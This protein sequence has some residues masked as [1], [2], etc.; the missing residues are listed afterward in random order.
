ME[1]SGAIIQSCNLLSGRE[2]MLSIG[3]G[4]QLDKRSLF[5]QHCRTSIDEASG[6]FS[7][8]FASFSLV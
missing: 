4:V 5:L 7:A 1:F 3:D 8:N 6:I 2:W